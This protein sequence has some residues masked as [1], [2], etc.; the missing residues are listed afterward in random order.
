MIF[1]EGFFGGGLV[2]WCGSWL[3]DIAFIEDFLMIL[4]Y[5]SNLI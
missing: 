1:V 4:D 3:L 5:E 2:V